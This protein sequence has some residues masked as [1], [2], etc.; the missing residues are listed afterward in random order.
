MR[1]GLCGGVPRGKSG[2]A[3]TLCG[4]SGVTL[5]LE[6]EEEEEIESRPLTPPLDNLENL[7]GAEVGGAGVTLRGGAQEKRTEHVLP[8][9][10]SG[11]GVG[12]EA[13]RRVLRRVY[14]AHVLPRCKALQ[15]RSPAP[16]AAFSAASC[17]MCPHATS[18]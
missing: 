18:I 4:V 6:E 5:D 13:T 1:G 15:A 12:D 17:S 9:R 3:V 11:V 10:S 7:E 16:T 8:Q 14:Q 2:G